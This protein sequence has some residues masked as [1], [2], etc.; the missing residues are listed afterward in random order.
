[1]STPADAAP[2]IAVRE[3]MGPPAARVPADAPLGVAV[4]ELLRARTDRL[5]VT[6]PGGALA[7]VLTDVA[8][9]RAEIRGVPAATPCGELAVRC[10]PLHANADAALALARLGEHGEPRVPVV[11]RGRLAG[12]LTRADR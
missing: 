2:W 8:L 7:G 5:W 1:M 3:V 9:T 11:D 6:A 10:T 12:E 4:A